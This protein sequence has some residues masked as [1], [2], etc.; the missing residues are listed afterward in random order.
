M[1]KAFPGLLAIA[2]SGCATVLGDSEIADRAEATVRSS[3]SGGEP[4]IL[5]RVVRQDEAQRLCSIYRNAPPAGVAE[6]IESAQRATMRYPASGRLM[7]D[8]REGKRIAED[9]AGMMYSDPPGRTG[10]GNC[11]ACHQLAPR[12]L[13]FGTV[14]PSLTGYG[15]ARGASET[16][17]R[18][19]YERT[20]NAKAFVACSAMPRFGH[21]GVLTP[22]QIAHVVA[23]LLDPASPV[24]ATADKIDK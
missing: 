1:N 5:A 16:M 14:G 24:N 7:G 18:Y 23:F 11:Y 9:T 10:G 15:A 6:A 2:L 19:T 17:Q 21:N 8:W 22:E 3:F 4:R 12:E 13:A 20:Y